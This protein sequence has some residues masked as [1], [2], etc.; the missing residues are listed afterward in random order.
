MVRVCPNAA[1]NLAATREA[2]VLKY[3]HK[4]LCLPCLSAVGLA[5]LEMFLLGLYAM[6][7]HLKFELKGW[8][9]Q[10]KNGGMS[11]IGFMSSFVSKSNDGPSFLTN[12]S[13]FV[14]SDAQGQM[15]FWELLQCGC[16]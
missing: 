13:A 6:Q 16:Q 15:L 11:A 5:H 1:R 2:A 3:S 10:Q 12:S 7:P 9:L 8:S 14:C 4:A